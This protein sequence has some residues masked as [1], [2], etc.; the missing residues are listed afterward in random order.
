MVSQ[1]YARRRLKNIK[2]IGREILRVPLQ[3]FIDKQTKLLPADQN[4]NAD[5]YHWTLSDKSHRS[6]S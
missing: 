2:Q 5:L 6:E 3:L 4:H 1:N